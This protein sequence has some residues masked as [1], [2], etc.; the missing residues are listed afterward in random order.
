LSTPDT[1]RCCFTAHC[2][3]D[4][5]GAAIEKGLNVQP[6]DLIIKKG[7]NIKIDN[8]SCFFDIVKTHSTKAHTELQARKITTLYVLGVAT[9]SCV[10]SSIIDALALGY[11]VFVIEDGLQRQTRLRGMR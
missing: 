1:S 10:K 8:Y 3:A 2:V 7:T 9:D 4:T 6:N 5:P 11:K